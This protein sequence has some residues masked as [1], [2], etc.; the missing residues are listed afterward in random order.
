MR[1]HRDGP[2][3]GGLISGAPG[4]ARGAFSEARAR[5]GPA[6]G[7]GPRTVVPSQG[8]GTLRQN[9]PLT[10]DVSPGLAAGEASAGGPGGSS[11]PGSD[12]RLL[13]APALP[14]G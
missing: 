6:D 7:L 14:L 9:R 13:E 5:P 3:R 8:Y 11:P 2:A 1:P 12:R 4:G 10:R